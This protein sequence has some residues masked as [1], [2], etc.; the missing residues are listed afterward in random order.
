MSYNPFG[1]AEV[2]SPSLATVNVN[3]Y[4]PF[5]SPE[6]KVKEIE[7]KSHGIIEDFYSMTDFQST[8]ILQLGLKLVD[9]SM[10]RSLRLYVSFPVPTSLTLRL[11]WLK[12]LLV[13]SLRC[14]QL[15]DRC[16]V[17][18]VGLILRSPLLS[19]SRW[20]LRIE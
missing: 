13:Q 15:Y 1:D 10:V 9:M 19:V 5:T 12:T 7:E 8:P 4:N 17:L 14:F 3:V 16:I 6:L 20:G 11:C 18:A 2:S